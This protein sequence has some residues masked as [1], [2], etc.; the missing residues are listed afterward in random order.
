M[1]GLVS[2][3]RAIE[4]LAQAADEV[5][6]S[7][8]S[9][10]VAKYADALKPERSGQRV[11]VDFETLL[12]HRRGNI[13]RE[14]PAERAI[15]QKHGRAEEAAL[16]I[17]AQRLMREI[18]VAEKQKDLTPTHDVRAAAAEAVAKLKTALAQAQDQTAEEIARACGAEP[19]IVLA[20]LTRFARL[21]LEAF[22]AALQDSQFL[23]SAAD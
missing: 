23:Q 6:Q 14:R 3:G 9:R 4:L 13:H 11:M 12:E 10:Y 7:S 5:T 21:G 18:G 17:R 8:L 2:L 1:Q 16:N 22:V 19:Q 20:H 15:K